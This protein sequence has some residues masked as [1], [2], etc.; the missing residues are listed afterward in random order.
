MLGYCLTR[1]PVVI[2]EVLDK[3]P[4]LA[5]IWLSHVLLASLGYYLCRKGGRWFFVYIPL[6]CYAIWFGATD[7]WDKS[8]GPAI[9]QELKPFF[10]QWNIAMVLVIAAPLV[11]L[12]NGRRRRQ[13]SF[14]S[15]S[16]RAEK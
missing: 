10:V 13:K 15:V 6:A 12:W 4:T 3:E 7:L 11:G 2:A 1:F 5:A 9:I 14:D 16:S 8:V